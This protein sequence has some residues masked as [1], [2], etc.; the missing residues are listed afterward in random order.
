MQEIKKNYA[1][2]EGY[3]EIL[4]EL[5]ER[6]IKIRKEIADR[7]KYAKDF[8]DLSENAA[9][10]EAREAQ[11]ENENRI[12]ILEDLVLIT[13]VVKRDKNNNSIQIGSSFKVELNGKEF[14]YSIV[15][16]E[17]ADPSSFKISH[18]SPLGKYFLGKK[19]GQNVE[20]KSPSGTI[21]KFKIEEI[22]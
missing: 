10:T 5:N 3:K 9:Y 15:G 12:K 18:E 4:N 17:E 13:E 22:K 21:M 7:I 6:K 2:E 14:T 11:N 19:K 16:P 1:T 20:F 8:G